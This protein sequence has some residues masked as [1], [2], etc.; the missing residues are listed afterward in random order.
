MKHMAE[1]AGVPYQKMYDNIILNRYDTLDFNERTMLSN[2]LFEELRGLF[3][4][5]GFA[6]QIKRL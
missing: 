3:K 1:K 4:E 2:A 6:I 5:L